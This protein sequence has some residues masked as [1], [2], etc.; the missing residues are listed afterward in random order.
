MCYA[1]VEI[2]LT[3]LKTQ[4]VAK[5][6]IN[7][8]NTSLTH[9]MK[10]ND[11]SKNPCLGHPS[12]KIISREIIKATCNDMMSITKVVLFLLMRWNY[13]RNIAT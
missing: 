8:G 1:N 11:Y 5:M 9:L 4:K 10:R 12:T 2:T 13:A 3:L 6:F 7:L